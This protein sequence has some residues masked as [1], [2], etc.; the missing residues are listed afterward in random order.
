MNAEDSQINQLLY[1]SFQA[2]LQDDS[3]EFD[4]LLDK[5]QRS[6]SLHNSSQ[7]MLDRSRVFHTD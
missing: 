4:E 3:S 6:I 7:Q 2:V 5:T 1:N